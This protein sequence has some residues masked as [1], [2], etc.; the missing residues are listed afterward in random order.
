MRRHDQSQRRSSDLLVPCHPAERPLVQNSIHNLERFDTFTTS[1]HHVGD[2]NHP[3]PIGTSSFHSSFQNDLSSSLV[4]DDYSDR[5]SAFQIAKSRWGGA[6]CCSCEQNIPSRIE[7]VSLL[8]IHLFY[9]T[10]AFLPFTAY[11]AC[12]QR[13]QHYTWACSWSRKPIFVASRDDC[14]GVDEGTVV[15]RKFAHQDD[16]YHICKLR[17]GRTGRHRHVHTNA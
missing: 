8:F 3:K 7:T 13:F 6:G 14:C 1:R 5:A 4:N 10:R 2:I 15:V 9:T 17:R 11:A 12:F 16:A